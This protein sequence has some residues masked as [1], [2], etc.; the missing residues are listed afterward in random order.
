MLFRSVEFMFRIP[1][2][3]KI[4]DGVTKHLLRLAMKGVL[5]EKTRTRIKKTGWNAPA[6]LWFAAESREP[7]NDLVR[8]RRFRERGVYRV[9]QVE[10]ILSEHDDIVTGGRQQENH[11]MFLWQLVNLELWFRACVDGGPRC[12]PLG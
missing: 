1:G 3:L 4:R 6:H 9:D 2:H 11:M 5:P 12:A 8:S 7:L 10:R